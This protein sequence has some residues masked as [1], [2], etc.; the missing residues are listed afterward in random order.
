MGVVYRAF[1]SRLQRP[2]AIK[3]FPDFAGDARAVQRLLHEGRSASAL[4]HP[5]VCT[6][7]E[8][9]ESADA[10]YLVMEYVE[11]DPLS[12]LIQA[13]PLPVDDIVQYGAQIAGAV[14]HAHVRGVIHRDLK[15]AN[16]VV[17]PDGRAKV[18]DFG[19]ALRQVDQRVTI[20]GIDDEPTA[21]EGRLLGTVAYMAPEALCG[22][23]AD[24][25]TDIWSLGVVLYEMAAGAVP[26][27]GG[28]P[29]EVR[30]RIL[31]QA[32][33]PLPATVPPT[34]RAIIQRCLQ[35][36]PEQR[37]ADATMVRGALEALQ[38]SRELTSA[39]RV[40]GRRSVVVLPFANLSSD[41]D[42]E[43]FSEGLTDEIIAELSNVK[44]LRVISRTSST[45]LKG[46]TQ[47]IAEL[48][49]RLQVEYVLEGS[50][51]RSGG[52][53]RVT[54]KLVEAATDSPV[55]G[56]KYSGTLED[57]FAIQE[58]MSRS[59]VDALRVS[60]TVEE[61]ERLAKRP[62]ADARAYEWYLRARHEMLRFT[63]DGL[64]RALEYLQKSAEIQGEN[65][66]LLAARGHVYWQFVNAGVS[67]NLSYLDWAEQCARQV[68]EIDPAFAQG[69]R[70]L[71]L[72]TLHRGDP[73][74]ALRQLKQSIDLDSSDPESLM[75]GSL[76]AA[77]SGKMELA[78]AWGSR[79]VELDRLTPL[80]QAVP[81]TLASMRGDFER[82]VEIFAAQ[83]AGILDNPALRLLYG[84]NLAL[85]GRLEQAHAVLGDLA[86]ALPDNPFGQ[87]AVLYGHALKDDRDAVVA[88]V[89]PELT[90][91]LG[92]DAQYSWFLAQCHALVGEVDAGIR[93]VETA[94]ARG[95]INYPLLGKIDPFLAS[96]RPDQ[97]F[98]A[99]MARVKRQWEA[100]DV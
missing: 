7:Y 68:L 33:P 16:V 41:P 20:D 90:E 4:N 52:Q 29:F 73:Q 40:D 53:L 89:T 55:W 43:F 19:I 5:H 46:D 22:M 99:L 28:T 88:G 76:L 94:V 59:I 77:F 82:A 84:Q 14:A 39:V 95:L 75:W 78:E 71:G 10:A 51:R 30:A 45:Q 96:L 15:S 61:D 34:L 1:D 100:F 58:R 50:V 64:E 67:A 37:Y 57:V 98:Q 21:D 49:S 23:P 91:V 6:V 24:A 79:L 92:S 35:K 97:R 66:L 83:Y 62:I 87:L 11:G 65:A 72:V 18:L 69:H 26:F 86:R 54:A 3:A 27:R 63:E 38:S 25:R 80:Y 9:G 32:P 74:G 81:G 44:G 13:G 70:L 56:Q 85:A 42:N 12:A 47:N 48:A 17:T 31:D 2:V 60:L 8:V 36:D 93:W